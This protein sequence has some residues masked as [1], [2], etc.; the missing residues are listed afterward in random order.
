MNTDS[1]NAKIHQ[2]RNVRFFR[3]AK[4]MK[5]EDFAERIGVRQPVVTKIERQ[6][7]ID[8][9]MLLKCAEVLD[10]PVETIK[11]FE[12]EQM[13]DSFT[14]HIDKVQNTNGAISISRDG[15]T[16]TNHNYPLEKI[17][18]LNQ[19]NAEL[20]ERLLQAE[21]EKIAFL[22]KMLAERVHWN[23]TLYHQLRHIED[24][25]NIHFIRQKELNGLG[26]A[27][28]HA[29]FHCGDEAF[30]VLL[31]DT[32]INS[33]ILFEEFLRKTIKE[34]DDNSLKKI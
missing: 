18:E 17:M 14:Y 34:I 32:V 6:R 5:Q 19:K 20:Y 24:M 7:I 29:R 23:E 10:I 11:E 15:T 13:F 8:E 25:A 33:I 22:E 2:G 21:K 27:I 31:G 12:P 1:I 28:Y 3:N 30:A 9:Q 26:D 4:N 16:P